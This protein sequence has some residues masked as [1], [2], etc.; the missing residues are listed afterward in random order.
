MLFA[1]CAEKN[2]KDLIDLIHPIM[3][4]NSNIKCE[5]KLKR[6]SIKTS[7]DEVSDLLAAN[8]HSGMS[9]DEHRNMLKLRNAPLI[10]MFESYESFPDSIKLRVDQTGKLDQEISQRIRNLMDQ[11]QKLIQ[12]FMNLTTELSSEYGETE[13]FEIIEEFYIETSEV[14]CK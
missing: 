6:D 5:L 10:K 2:S 14:N 8:F 9:P 3:E 7:W 1:S 12:R 4:E 13:V 11:Q